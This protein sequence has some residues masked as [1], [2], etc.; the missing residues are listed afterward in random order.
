MQLT[1]RFRVVMAS[2]GVAL[3]L[4]LPP[5]PSTHTST[6]LKSRAIILS[7]GFEE[8]DGQSDPKVR[9]L[10]RGSRYGV[11]ITPGEVVLTLAPDHSIRSTLRL[12]FPGANPAAEVS[13]LEPFPG[14]VHYVTGRDA[15]K[16]RANITT[17]HKV[18]YHGLYAGI[19][20]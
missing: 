18:R 10:L 11:F 1:S 15:S 9:F 6:R 2:A 20:L 13:V 7:R 14:R 3:A 4:T 12:N 8:N 5:V 16:W 17:F 19:D